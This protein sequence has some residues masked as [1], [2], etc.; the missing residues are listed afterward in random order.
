M[1]VN[2]MNEIYKN[3]LSIFEDLIKTESS[4]KNI[5]LA[6][7]LNTILSGVFIANYNIICYIKFALRAPRKSLS[8]RI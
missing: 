4:Q 8:K 6:D 1:N 3:K 7:T 5:A 2:G